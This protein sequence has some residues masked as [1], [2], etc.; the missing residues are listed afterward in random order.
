M[1][2]WKAGGG[3]QEGLRLT[4]TGLILLHKQSDL[5]R[6]YP[7]VGYSTSRACPRGM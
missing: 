7:V 3:E 5:E 1:R 4:C 6:G 2:Q